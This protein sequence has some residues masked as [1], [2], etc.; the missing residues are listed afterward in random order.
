[1]KI[2][3]FAAGFLLL[4]SC[5]LAAESS[6]PFDGKWSGQYDGGMGEPMTLTYVFKT[7]GTAVTGSVASS[8]DNK[9]TPIKEGKIDGKNISFGADVDFQGMTLKF[10]YKGVLSGEELKLT[11]DTD[12][13]GGMGGPGGGAPGGGGFGGGA[14]GGGFGGGA[15]GGGFGGGAPGGGFGGGAPGGGFGGGAP[16]G[17]FGGGAPGGGFGGAPGGGFGGGA[18]GGGFGGG[19]P[20]GAAGGGG[21]AEFTAK[22]EKSDKPSTGAAGKWLIKDSDTEIKIEMK[23]EGSK[24]TGTLDNTQMPG[25]IELK[26]GKID[27]NKISFTIV[28]QMNDQ[29]MKISWTGTLSGDEIKFKRESASGGAPGGAPGG[30]FGG[31]AP[32]GGFGGGA[33]GGGFGGGAP[34]GGAPGGGGQSGSVT[35]KKVK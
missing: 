9:E 3:A 7:S 28:R 35:V 8:I 25:A 24:I 30:G 20:G 10:K 21:S 18:P 23:V 4:T 17:G 19:A 31:G 15:P 6:S 1:M 5:V 22:R 11:F 14:P 29:D 32:G 12:M 16:G 33:P 2:W 13:G 27:G 26:D 34:G